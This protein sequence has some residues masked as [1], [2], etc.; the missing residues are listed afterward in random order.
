MLYTNHLPRVGANDEGTWRRLIV[1]PFNA[2]IDGNSDIKNYADYLA[3]K[4]GGVVLSWIIEGAR[5]VIECNFKLKIPQ[6]VS[7]AISHYREN[8]DWLSMFIEDCCEVDPSYTQLEF[9]E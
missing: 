8:N 9:C 2:K 6:C 7:D 1:I 3:E 5:K 4:A